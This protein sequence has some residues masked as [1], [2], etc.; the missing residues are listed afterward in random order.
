VT[1]LFLLYSGPDGSIKYTS[2]NSSV[3]TSK[4]TSDN[5]TNAV[6]SNKPPLP[7]EGPEDLETSPSDISRGL[8]EDGKQD[9]VEDF[10]PRLDNGVASSQRPENTGASSQRPDGLEAASQRPDSLGGVQERGRTTFSTIIAIEELEAKTSTSKP[11]A[12]GGREEVLYTIPLILVEEA[13]GG[14]EAVVEAVTEPTK[15]YDWGGLDEIFDTTTD[16]S[17]VGS[18]TA[19]S[20]RQRT[21]FSFENYSVDFTYNSMSWSPKCNT[22]SLVL[23]N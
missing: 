9:S 17:L 16:A 21:H 2:V 15:D 8:S 12:E 1:F 13:T 14:A 19:S 6:V 7:N 4:N 5:A 3:N 23:S 10:S 18:S 20:T 22:V 11:R